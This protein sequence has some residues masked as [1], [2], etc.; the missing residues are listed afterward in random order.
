MADI[1]HLEVT[2]LY[3]LQDKKD[4][5][6]ETGSRETKVDLFYDYE[7]LVRLGKKCLE[8]LEATKNLSKENNVRFHNLHE[9]NYF[10]FYFGWQ[11]KWKTYDNASFVSL[12]TFDDLARTF[13][14]ENTDSNKWV[15]NA[16]NP[17]PE[18][19]LQ[20]CKYIVKD[21]WIAYKD[22]VL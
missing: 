10:D 15:I 8:I 1:K 22:H 4:K 19:E 5:F 6:G 16:F 9:S 12:I 21:L 14:L 2:G 3:T 13:G 17:T 18:Q 7:M 20:L 11:Y